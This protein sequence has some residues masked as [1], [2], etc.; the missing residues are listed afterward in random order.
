MQNSNLKWSSF[1]ILFFNFYIFFYF[2]LPLE[3]CYTLFEKFARDTKLEFNAYYPVNNKKKP[4]IV[5]SWIGEDPSLPSIMLNSHMDVV[6]A[7][8]VRF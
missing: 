2:I 6:P 7:E 5:I 4:V 3:K 1:E 8:K